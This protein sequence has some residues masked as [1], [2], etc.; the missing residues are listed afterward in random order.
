MT[1]EVL[2]CVERE[3]SLE[4]RVLEVSLESKDCLEIMDRKVTIPNIIT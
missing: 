3:E 1:K 2:V 4:D